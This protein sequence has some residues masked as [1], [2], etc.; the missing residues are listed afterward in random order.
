[1]PYASNIT[2]AHVNPTAEG[3]SFSAGSPVAFYQVDNKAYQN[4][5]AEGNSYAAGTPKLSG[6]QYYLAIPSTTESFSDNAG[7]TVSYNMT[8]MWSFSEGLGGSDGL[9]APFESFS[10]GIGLIDAYSATVSQTMYENMGGD[11]SD[12]TNPLTYGLSYSELG[13]LASFYS[14]KVQ[15]T[16]YENMGG[17]DAVSKFAS[18]T[19]NS[20]IKIIAQ[21]VEIPNFTVKIAGET[22]TSQYCTVDIEGMINTLVGVT[23]TGGTY[24]YPASGGHTLV[25][26]PNTF[27]PNV[28]ISGVPLIG[29]VPSAATNTAVYVDIPNSNVPNNNW[30]QMFNFGSSLD[31]LGG[32][33]SVISQNPVESLGQ[34]FTLFGLTATETADG[35]GSQ[36]IVSSSAK[37]YATRGIYGN[38]IMNKQLSL[39]LGISGSNITYLSYL[40]KQLNLLHY[41]GQVQY[42][43][44]IPYGSTTSVSYPVNTT[45]TLYSVRETCQFL[46]GRVGINLIWATFDNPMQSAF[47]IQPTMT[48][49]SALQSL[50][51]QVGAVLRWSGGNTYYVC[52]PNYTIGSFVVPNAKL[53]TANGL[54]FEALEDLE[55]GIGGVV[56]PIPFSPNQGVF[57]IPSPT[58]TFTN[59]SFIYNATNTSQA[60]TGLPA[61]TQVA[62]VTKILTVNDP[63]QVFDLPFDYD[64]AFIQILVPNPNAQAFSGFPQGLSVGTTNPFSGDSDITPSFTFTGSI[65]TDNPNQWWD[66]AFATPLAATYLGSVLRGNVY[67]PIAVVDNTFFPTNNRYVAAGNFSLNIGVTRKGLASGGN[68]NN[69]VYPRTVQYVKTYQGTI[70]CVF[71][72]VMPLPGMFASAQVDGVLVQGVIESVSFTPPGFLTLQIAQYSIINWVVPTQIVGPSSS[73]QQAP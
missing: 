62:H 48:L 23:A 46:A 60:G 53:I 3:N 33:W 22:V 9:S 42:V 34:Q 12:A 72:G 50:V 65:V 21:T 47:T 66:F 16:I 29:S 44:V 40:N 70:T 17:S 28:G 37:G 7:L 59:A 63:P 51:G 67:T 43:N 35:G 36:N 27:S 57:T 5:T 54:F 61:V 15:Q 45:P 55:Y 38:P 18:I 26:L 8:V 56:T 58:Y 11:S 71:Y 68:G 39:V 31:Y 2:P 1:M 4:A 25:F 20:T 49:L 32:T 64:Q 30:G 13:G 52:P 41:S 6:W 24:V 69:L 14:A 10:E 19:N 73:S